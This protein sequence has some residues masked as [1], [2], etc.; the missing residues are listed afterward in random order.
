MKVLFG[1]LTF[2]GGI[3]LILAGIG[4]LMKGEGVAFWAL[5]IGVILTFG[6]F[7]VLRA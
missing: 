1:L 2:V 7:K 3:I 5:I 4:G 6:G